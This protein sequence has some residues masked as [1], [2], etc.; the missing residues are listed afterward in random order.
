MGRT[1]SIPAAVKRT[2]AIRVMAIVVSTASCRTF[3]FFAPYSW[4]ITTLA[5]TEKP[6]KKKTAILTTMV[7]EPTAASAWV[8]T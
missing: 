2:P 8:L 1:V 6:L 4:P 5:P 7:V 3:R